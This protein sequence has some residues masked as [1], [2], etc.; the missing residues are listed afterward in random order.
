ML[1]KIE[2]MPSSSGWQLK[3]KD[4]IKGL[5]LFLL[6]VLSETLPY[7]KEIFIEHNYN[8]REATTRTAFVMVAWFVQ[9]YAKNNIVPPQRDLPNAP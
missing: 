8:Y 1:N 2:K 4:W 9:R 5:G 3:A 6:L 7:L